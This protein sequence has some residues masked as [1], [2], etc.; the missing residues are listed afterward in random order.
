MIFSVH[1]A[2]TYHLADKQHRPLIFPDG[3][4]TPPGYA[5]FFYF[6][7]TIAVAAQTADVALRGSPM[8]L[9]VSAQAVLAFIFNAAVLG[10]MINIAAGLVSG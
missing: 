3:D 7:I 5:D 4:D 8:R 9:T 6:A 10:L 2:H 1:Y